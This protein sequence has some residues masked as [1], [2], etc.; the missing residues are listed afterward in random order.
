[1]KKN[2]LLI[3]FV[4]CPLL[5]GAQIEYKEEKTKINTIKRDKNY[6]YGEG[7]ADTE[8]EALELAE[9]ALRSAINGV[10][11]ERE[12]LQD[13]ET[14]VVNAVKRN[15]SRLQLKRGA[16]ERVFLY[17]AKDHIFAA[18][19]VVTIP[20][21]VV[22]KIEEK[23]ED[24]EEAENNTEENVENIVEESAS[25]SV[26]SPLLTQ[27]LRLTDMVSLQ[28]FLK[29]KKEEHAAMWGN[30]GSDIKANWYI[31]AYEGNEVKAVFDK[32]LNTRLNLL[33]GEKESLADYSRYKKIWF[34]LY[35]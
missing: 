8:K 19:E 2:L 10:V 11:A 30:V 4:L 21:G 7:I 24:V 33:T 31:V 17:V 27:L 35:N 15:S 14:I 5:V 22:E 16:F 9:D 12:S 1:M 25:E 13:T 34:T 20:R 32:G 18:E 28:N 6:V 29:T 23:A 26:H 3:A